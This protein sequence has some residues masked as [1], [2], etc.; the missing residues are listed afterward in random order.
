MK[1]YTVKEISKILKLTP[2][3]VRKLIKDGLLLAYDVG[4][5]DKYEVFRVSEEHLQKY[6]EENKA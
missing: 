3:T 2:A 4:S 5:G 1:I 6:L